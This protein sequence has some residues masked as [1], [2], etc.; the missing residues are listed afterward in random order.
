MTTVCNS[1]DTNYRMCTEDCEFIEDR[2]N[3]N[4][5][6]GGEIYWCRYWNRETIPHELDLTGV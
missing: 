2:E 3:P 4:T 6:V 5:L 1:K